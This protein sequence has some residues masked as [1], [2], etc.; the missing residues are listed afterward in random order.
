MSGEELMFSKCW[1]TSSGTGSCRASS[2]AHRSSAA[3]SLQMGDL[4]G[5]GGGGGGS[6]G[7]VRGGGVRGE[8]GYIY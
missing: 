6:E 5:G 1:C 2:R 3:I 4:G 7:G 8:G